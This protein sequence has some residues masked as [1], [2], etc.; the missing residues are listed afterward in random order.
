MAGAQGT[1]VSV[2][3]PAYNAARYLRETL[4]SVL[5]Q[6]YPDLEIIVVDDG[7]TDETFEIANAIAATDARLRVLRQANK[8]PGAARNLGIAQARGTLIAPLDAD[9]LW[10]PTKIAK[11]VSAMRQGG[12]DVGLVYTWS[13]MIDKDSRI[14]DQYRGECVEGDAY[15]ALVLYNFL[16]NGSTP[17][18][19]RD[20]LA[21]TGGYDEAFLYAQDYLFALAIAERYHFAVV[22]E[23]LVGYRRTSGSWSSN[24]VRLTDFH[25]RALA[26][27][28][29]RHPELPDCL[30]RWSLAASCFS[31]AGKSLRSGRFL[32]GL[33]LL[34]KSM[35][36]DPTL[37][38]TPMAR[39][40]RRQKP[41]MHFRDASPELG[42]LPDSRLFGHRR[43]AYIKQLR[44]VRP[45]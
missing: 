12:P 39:R 20:C 32:Q 43:H 25:R 45:A 41:G 14:I 9:D 35:L 11:Q 21:E 44:I 40:R 33:S 23:F 16:L 28:R 7:S 36:L 18:V 6:T 3:V 5:A 2:V 24:V 30:F 8:G 15:A 22:P 4:D 19:R 26:E 42:N 31:A 13:S 10:H 1:L 34:T 29:R 38:L 17:L 27:V 37:P